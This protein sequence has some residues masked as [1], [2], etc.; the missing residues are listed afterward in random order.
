MLIRVGK[1]IIPTD[2]IILDYD[3]DDR[4]PIILGHPFLAT[5]GAL[6]YVREVHSK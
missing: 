5:G 6:I 1:F 4:V 3:T 2:F